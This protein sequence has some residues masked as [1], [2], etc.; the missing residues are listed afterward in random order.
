MAKGWKS[1]DKEATSKAIIAPKDVEEIITTGI[2]VILLD[3]SRNGKS[4]N[5]VLR[6]DFNNPVNTSA[7]KPIHNINTY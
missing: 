5:L 6:I 1:K 4:C 2:M 7:I 3:M